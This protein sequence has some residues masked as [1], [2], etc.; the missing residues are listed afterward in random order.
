MD[1]KHPIDGVSILVEVNNAI[2]GV[3]EHLKHNATAS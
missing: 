1:F 3:V 2:A